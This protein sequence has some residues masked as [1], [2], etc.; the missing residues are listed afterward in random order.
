MDL[1][2]HTPLRRSIRGPLQTSRQNGPWFPS[3]WLPASL[4]TPQALGSA[5]RQATGHRPCKE[6]HI[7]C[8]KR[9]LQPIEARPSDR[10]VKGIA[11]RLQLGSGLTHLGLPAWLG[12]WLQAALGP[13]QWVHP[14]AWVD[15][16]VHAGRLRHRGTRPAS[17]NNSDSTH[18]RP[19]VSQST[20]PVNNN[21]ARG[22]CARFNM[23]LHRTQN[24][25]THIAGCCCCLNMPTSRRSTRAL[26]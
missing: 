15:D 1:Y 23:Y 2:P 18:T 25:N 12:P 10:S 8:C 5:H 4:P 3:S 24:S 26:R 13:V 6:K 22:T 11:F 16:K 9:K 21:N 17:S 19:G 7:L 14:A 20:L